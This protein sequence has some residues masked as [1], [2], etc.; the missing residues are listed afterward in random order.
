MNGTNEET[1]ANLVLENNNLIY[2]IANRFNNYSAKDDLYQVGVVGLISAYHNFDKTR[3]S[4][5]STYAFPY[6]LGEMKQYVRQDKGVK[7]SRD[8]TYLGLKIERAKELIMQRL[9]R[10]P[11][12]LEIAK[13]L[14]I[15]E[16]K[17]IEALQ[18]N[19]YVKSLDE[20]INDEGKELTLKDSIAQY[21]PYDKLD[22]IYLRD[23]LNDLSRD[24]K[25]LLNLRFLQDKTQIEAAHIMDISQVQ[26]SRY[27]QKIITRLKDHLYH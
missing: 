9:K 21:E 2:S 11:T 23:T 10:E 4:K 13:F 20:P 24:E 3:G 6:I 12:T 7:I 15:E 17:I 19:Y 27:E 25:R 14:E 26:V 5:F 1:I 16:Y 22:L 18:A 8:I